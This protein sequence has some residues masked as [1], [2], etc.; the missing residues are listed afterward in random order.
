MRVGTWPSGVLPASLPPLRTGRRLR[1]SLRRVKRLPSHAQP[2]AHSPPSIAAST[3]RRCAAP[4][5]RRPGA[6]GA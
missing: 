4:T 5:P 3:P 2:F 6:A 1:D